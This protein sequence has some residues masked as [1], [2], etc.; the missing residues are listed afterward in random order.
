MSERQHQQQVCV[1]QKDRSASAILAATAHVIAALAVIAVPVA[2]LLVKHLDAGGALPAAVSVGIGTL[3]VVVG[4]LVA[5]HAFPLRRV[6]H[7]E[8]ELRYRAEHD[9]LTGLANRGSLPARLNEAIGRAQRL[10]GGVAVMFLDLDD[11]KMVN[12][13]M[14]HAAGDALLREVASRLRETV[15]QGDTVARLGGDEFALVFEHVRPEVA[16]SIAT[17]LLQRVRKPYS[18]DG[19]RHDLTCSI[20]IA[21]FPG[22]ADEAAPLLGYANIAMQE[23]KR[24]SKSDF[25]FYSSSMQATLADRGR[26]QMLA[27]Q[28]WE[29]RLFTLHYQPIVD[30]SSM[31]LTGAEALLRWHSPDLGAVPPQEFVPA[32]EE[33][34][35]IAEV[36]DWV[37]RE[38]CM[39]AR[40]WADAGHPAFSVSVNIS[41]RHFRAGEAL[42]ASVRIALAES[43]LDA[44]RLQLE[45][46]E[47]AMMESRSESLL[48]LNQL[49]AIGVGIAIDDFGTGYSSLSY[50]KHFPVDSLKIDKLFVSELSEEAAESNIV[51][52]IVQLARGLGLAVIA[53]GVE[54]EAQMALLQRYG[55][56]TMQGYALGP[57]LPPTE[58]ELDVLRHAS[59]RET[60]SPGTATAVNL[61]ALT[62]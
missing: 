38:A 60:T 46:T 45:I 34:G 25:A 33:M 21:M 32:L 47:G 39:Q 49:K 55:C 58:F 52:A 19:R 35:L 31:Q 42:V 3:L 28:A 48:T 1:T 18:I 40:T 23:C 54:T 43:G 22:D 41:P 8:E 7:I 36:S 51:V 6:R 2:F 14:G 56:D 30:M 26:R 20:G 37:L 12:D 61:K 57:P 17:A 50:L 53:E 15:R 5:F 62:V 11:F 13:T 27:R 16:S 24:R 4:A 10:Q 44:S 29:G 9:V 59:W